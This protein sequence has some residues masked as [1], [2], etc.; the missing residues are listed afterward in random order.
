M[1]RWIALVLVCVFFIN[2][3]PFQAAAVEDDFVYISVVH[4]GRE[5]SC[6]V[7]KDG[8]QLLFAGEELASF[9]GYTYSVD[10][11]NAYFSRGMKTI[12]VN[13]ARSS[14]IPYDGTTYSENQKNITI[15]TSVRNIDGTYYFPGTQLLPWLS[16]KCSEEE[17]KLKITSDEITIWELLEEFN[18]D[19]YTF[20]FAKCCEDLGE[21]SK[22]VKAWAG[23]QGFGFDTILGWL[24][25][26]GGNS[27]EEHYYYDIFED[28]LQDQTCSES[29]LDELME[30]TEKFNQWM[31][32]VEI[33]EMEEELP[34]ELRAMG[35]IFEVIG[36]A[37]VQ[38]ATELSFYLTTMEQDNQEK[39]N[40]LK[41]IV[42]HGTGF[43]Q[44]MDAAA[45]TIIVEYEDR[46]L[47][48]LGKGIDTLTDI[49]KDL[50]GDFGGDI[51]EIALKVIDLPEMVSVEV[52]EEIRRVEFYDTIAKGSAAAY[53]EERDRLSDAAVSSM[54]IQNT[55]SM[56]YMY[57]YATE[58]NWRAMYD[59]AVHLGKYEFA[60]EYA[61][62]ADATEEMAAKFLAS[63]YAQL[64][65]SPKYGDAEAQR[66]QEY[67]DRL[68]EMFA[69]LEYSEESKS[70][71]K[72][73]IGYIGKDISEVVNDLGN[74]YVDEYWDG[75]H[76]YTYNDLGI[77]FFFDDT[78]RFSATQVFSVY[79]WQDRDYGY[80]LSAQ[81]TYP[82][83]VE[84][85]A[86]FNTDT[87]P[88]PEGYHLYDDTSLPYQYSTH[89]VLDGFQYYFDW[90]DDPKAND[91]VFMSVSIPYTVEEQEPQN[92]NSMSQEDAYDM[93]CAYWDY[94]ED[95]PD[96]YLNEGNSVEYDG[97]LYYVYSLS[98]M[99]YSEDGSP[100]HLST[101]DWLYIN[102]ETGKCSDG[103]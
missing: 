81:M 58:Q 1:K 103:L 46:I 49:L 38:F 75:G 20:D 27:K 66:K 85:V 10:G 57:L 88:E 77:C 22:W 21:N 36:S 4:D 45:Q 70:I 102:S 60:E 7:I 37:P 52:S 15:K 12:R 16:V 68:K 14:L 93:A 59:Y 67:T 41:Y 62:R 19:D 35:V 47:G 61:L 79:A 5:Q 51:F 17:G 30:D 98:W 23:M 63:T 101:I 42:L 92:G 25:S 34:D 32:W 89:F 71:S 83:I 28:M 80:G 8:A 69:Q 74:D 43:P 53:K 84:A 82:E 50:M 96:L 24:P 39:L 48:I 65:D 86:I 6:K 18:P 99:V 94:S 91:S 26:L 97:T 40:A 73:Y 13:M 44:S 76:C 95:E 55:R 90:D 54:G 100:S 56:A 31:E 78:Y 64:N 72:G 29:S 9:G 87:I 3:L 11:D 2:L 33:L